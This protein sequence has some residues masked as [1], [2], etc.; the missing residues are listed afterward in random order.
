MVSF[1]KKYSGIFIKLGFLASVFLIWELLARFVISS[2]NLIPPVSI[3]FVALWKNIISGEIIKYTLY[4]LY[5]IFTGI[6]IGM[7]AAF[8]LTAFYMVNKSFAHILD[9]V[10]SIMHPLPGIALLPIVMLIVGLGAK[11][12][13]IIIVHSVIWPVIV[14]SIAGF[15]TVPK[16]QIELGRSLGMSELHLVFSVMI[17]NAFPHIFSGLKIAW[18]RSWRALVGA[19]MVFGATGLIGGLGWYIYQKRYFLEIPDVFAGL[20]VI[21]IIGIMIEEVL[22]KQVEKRTIIKWGISD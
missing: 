18:S 10:I 14:N 17:P 4:S 20:F 19:E 1:R 6:A 2:T 11:A 8:I 21:V 15:R 3:I 22:M 12:I 5:L 16:T 7:I 9:L 13:I